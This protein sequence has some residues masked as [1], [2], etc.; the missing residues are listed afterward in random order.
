MSYRGTF[1]IR[2][3][4]SMN[5]SLL[6]LVVTLAVWGLLFLL[7]SRFVESR[8][9]CVVFRIFGFCWGLVLGIVGLGGLLGA[10]LCLTSNGK[11]LADAFYAL[12][13]LVIYAGIGLFALYGAYHCCLAAVR[14]RFE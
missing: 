1:S 2:S 8:F 6:W 12:L 4:K 5:S 7:E 3:G 10:F 13:E 9:A 14:G 11:L